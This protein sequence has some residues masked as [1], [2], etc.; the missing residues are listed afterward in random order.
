MNVIH[1]HTLLP[2]VRLQLLF[3]YY[4]S[5]RHLFN[6]PASIHSLLPCPS[7]PLRSKAYLK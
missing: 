6:P 3:S 4:T 1:S 5:V 2:D 7:T